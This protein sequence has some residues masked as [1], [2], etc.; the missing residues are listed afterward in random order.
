[1]EKVRPSNESKLPAL[2][3]SNHVCSR[4]ANARMVEANKS[5]DAGEIEVSGV[6]GWPGSLGC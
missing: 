2:T 4:E 3:A 1:L 6:E 5:S